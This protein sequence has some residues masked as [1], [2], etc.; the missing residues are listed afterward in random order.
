MNRTINEFLN[1]YRNGQRQFENW[2]FNQNQS[3]AEHDLSDVEFINCILP[4][5]FRNTKLTNSKF[6]SCNIK[7]ADFR[8]ADLTNGLIKH[9]AIEATMF[10]EALTANFRFIENY[11]YGS[12]TK[13]G[14]FEE[15][16]KNSDDH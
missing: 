14:D 9:C 5:D 6:V 2:D 8:G 15:I 13:P 16:F 12:T 10:K 1:A 3:V 4:L 11:C 7:T